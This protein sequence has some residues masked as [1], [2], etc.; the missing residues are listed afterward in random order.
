MKLESLRSPNSIG[1]YAYI[2]STTFLKDLDVGNEKHCR[3]TWSMRIDAKNTPWRAIGNRSSGKKTYKLFDL[4]MDSESWV[5]ERGEK[6]CSVDCY[7][8]PN[9][10]WDWR[11]TKQLAGLCANW[12]EIDTTNHAILSKSDSNQVIEEVFEQ[13]ASSNLPMPSHYVLSGSGGIHLYWFYPITPAYYWKVN[14]WRSVTNKLID[15]LIEGGT[16]WSVDVGASRD[17]SRVMRM[18]G[19]IHGKSGRTVKAFCNNKAVYSFSDLAKKLGL[20]VQEDKLSLVNSSHP[21]EPAIDNPPVS[22]TN[23]SLSKSKTKNIDSN[24]LA[25]QKSNGKH[26]IRSWWTTIYYEVLSHSRRNGVREG[27][28]DSTAFILFVALRH[29]VSDAS[30]WERIQQINID[31][32]GLTESELKSYL[33]TAKTVRYRY[34]KST[35]ASYLDSQIGVDPSFLYKNKQCLSAQEVTA[36]KQLGAQKTA[37]FKSQQTLTE[38]CNASR[39]LVVSQTLTQTNLAKASSKSLSTVKRYWVKIQAILEGVISFPSIY[40][41]PKRNELVV[42]QS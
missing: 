10:F 16:L 8:T 7:I 14:N 41:P 22:S 11:N 20:S 26:N 38:L 30:A 12:L 24:R 33:G 40:T 19:T 27:S 32:I 2:P 4:Y 6:L 42:N 15:G 31:L 9:Q 35:L 25:S 1:D 17:P 28:R 13:L 29:M 3:Y 39:K 36:R 34:S 37:I 21:V 5:K 18:P 23:K